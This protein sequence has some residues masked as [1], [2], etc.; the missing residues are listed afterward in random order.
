MS[1]DIKYI[2]LKN[3]YKKIEINN[4]IL[5]IDPNYSIDT[6]V[7]AEKINSETGNY[8]NGFNHILD[9][10]FYK[11]LEDGNISIQKLHTL[12]NEEYRKIIETIFSKKRELEIFN[13]ITSTNDIY[14]KFFISINNYVTESLTGT[15]KN[16]SDSL[17]KMIREA[18]KSMNNLATYAL[19]NYTDGI[20]KILDSFA[21]IVKNLTIFDYQYLEKWADFGWTAL[22]EQSINFFS[23]DPLSQDNA[24]KMCLVFFTEDYINN[25]FEKLSSNNS[26]Y[27]YVKEA[28]QLFNNNYYMGCSM[29]LISSIDRLLSETVTNHDKKLIGERAINLIKKKYL[30]KDKE[31]V[32]NIY[33]LYNL[34]VYLNKLF[35]YGDNF[36][37]QINNLNRNYLFHGWQDK[38]IEIGR[39]D[40][41]KLLNCL[42]N[43]QLSIEDIKDVIEIKVETENL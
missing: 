30:E 15:F 12:T 40:C 18:S 31:D 11:E 17:S 23:E 19:E 2:K 29:L 24:D 13:S 39:T 28:Q 21:E 16:C 32:V 27:K 4:K 7:E 38:G 25:M 6:F 9:E 37:E 42:Y 36:N 8:K 33:V 35:K 41:I 3:N 22:E 1:K 26:Y 10:V 34:C 14:A 5:S 20:S 43:L